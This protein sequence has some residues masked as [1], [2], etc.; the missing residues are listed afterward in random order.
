[1]RVYLK[2]LL[3]D[4]FEIFEAENGAEG[5]KTALAVQP[6]AIISDLMMPVMNGLQFCREIKN[7]TSTSHIPVILLTSQS[8]ENSQIS[9][10]EAG[11]DV[12]LTKP[13]KKELLIRVI[14]NFIQNREK[15]YERT[16]QN[17]LSNDPLYPENLTLNKLDEEFLK[18]LVAY[19]EANISN[20]EIDAL[21]ICKTMGISR[22][23]LYSK[24]KTLTSQSV[25]EFIR[26]VRLKK[27]LQFLLEGKLAISQIV[28]EVGFNSHSY[29]DKCFIK[30]YGMGPK[31]YINK[32]KNLKGQG[33][34]E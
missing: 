7:S 27:S 1:M 2:L 31:E 17:I 33:S 16:R 13:V 15:L 25:H 6:T 30:Q 19:I 3:S 4:T 18:N 8:E 11:A 5:L 26:S 23:V 10:Y 32:K 21:S 12:Y 14:L 28:F 24:I 29:F 34:T 20:P 22:T 9:G